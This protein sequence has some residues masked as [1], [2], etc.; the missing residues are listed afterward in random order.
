L[1]QNR[2]LG[3]CLDAFSSR[4]PAATEPVIGRAFARAVGSQTAIALKMVKAPFISRV[5]LLRCGETLQQS[6]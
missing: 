1:N 6:V 2:A 5:T 3:F 4:E